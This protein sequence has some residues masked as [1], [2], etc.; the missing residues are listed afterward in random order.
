MERLIRLATIMTL[1]FT[2]IPAITQDIDLARIKP[3]VIGAAEDLRRAAVKGEL[4]LA[5]YEDIIKISCQS[6]TELSQDKDFA[7]LL[8]DYEK[9]QYDEKLASDI[10]ETFL[11][12][13]SFLEFLVTERK[14]LQDA[15]LSEEAVD[16]LLGQITRV[17]LEAAD[18]RLDPKALLEDLQR[19]AAQSCS[20]SANVSA[21]VKSNEKWCN[22]T[23]YG[24]FALGAGATLA[25]R[26]VPTAHKLQ[27]G[28]APTMRPT[29]RPAIQTRHVPTMIA[30]GTIVF[31]IT[32]PAA[33]AIAT[34]PTVAEEASTLSFR[35]DI[36]GV[37][38]I[39]K[40][41]A[42]SINSRS[43]IC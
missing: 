35:F 11:N 1:L 4:S 31:G 12:F 43:T 32:A 15:G 17:R 33:A 39:G 21:S 25:D 19:L 42:G 28:A 10:R 18:F 37:P 40:G 3:L 26:A 13:R 2:P 5:E 24:M 20:A 22:V 30:H 16:E 6:L 8:I 36:I 23:K 34:A 41:R 27:P 9:R 14:L 38:S 29:A 7:N